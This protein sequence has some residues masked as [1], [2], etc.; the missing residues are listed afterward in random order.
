MD[1]LIVVNRQDK[2]LGSKNK[3]ACHTLKGVLH[4]GFSVFVFNKKGQLLLQKR[5]QKKK[6]WPGF[7]SNTCCSHPRPGESYLQAGK[8]RLK[9]ELGF[10]C[11]LEYLDKFYYRAVYKNIGS[12]NEICAVLIG[13]YDGR[14]KP[15][16]KEVAAIRWL[17][18]D[19]LSQELKEKPEV[20]TPW[21]KKEL[22]LFPP[23]EK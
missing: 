11:D 13:K 9:E 14:V 3:E 12:E 4:R 23:L 8:R 19:Q 16:P 7:W 1:K 22:L 5:S 10:S 17:D 15:N 6:L 18:F 20:F 21:L 2:V